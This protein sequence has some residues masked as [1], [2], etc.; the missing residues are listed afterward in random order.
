AWLTLLVDVFSRSIIGYHLSF[1]PPSFYSVAMALRHAILR[2]DEFLKRFP[3]VKNEWPCSGVPERLICDNGAEFHSQD[4]RDLCS[5]LGISLEFHQK[6]TPQHKPHVERVLGTFNR[7][8]KS[9]PS[10][11]HANYIDKG[12]HK[13][14][15]YASVSFERLDRTAVRYIVD[16]YQQRFHRGLRG[17]PDSV[18]RKGVEEMPTRLPPSIADLRAIF[19]RMEL[20]KLRHDG[21]ELNT[22]RYITSVEAMRS[23]RSSPKLPRNGDVEV[24]Y[25]D[26]DCTRISVKHPGTG[27]YIEFRSLRHRELEGLSF[28]QYGVISRRAERNYG[29]AKWESFCAAREDIRRELGF[30]DKKRK[31]RLTRRESRTESGVKIPTAKIEAVTGRKPS[32]KRTAKPAAPANDQTNPTGHRDRAKGWGSRIREVA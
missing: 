30:Y 8:F 14:E 22:L 25:Y 28:F 24:W 6:R 19:G 5:R 29:D 17:I 1:D 23:L 26:D 16:V 4:L 20:R 7:L 13:P 2:K 3:K 15:R 10:T 21:I 27:E 31:R 12:E 18:W 11:T 32:Q 9:M